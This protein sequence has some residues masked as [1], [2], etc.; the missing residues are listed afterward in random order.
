MASKQPLTRRTFLKAA[1]AL[2]GWAALESSGLNRIACAAAGSGPVDVFY[3]G[4]R[5]LPY[6][7]LTF[8]DCYNLDLLQELEQMLSAHRHVQVTFFPTGTALENTSRDD[9]DLWGRLAAQGHEIGSHSYQHQFA[10]TLSA[11]EMQD[12]FDR[13]LE[14]AHQA[15]GYVPAVRFARPAYGELAFAFMKLCEDRGLVPTMWST[16]WGTA[17]E[18]AE[19]E[20][21]RMR[22][23]EIALLHIR[24]WDLENTR[25]AI[26]LMAE[27]G[28]KGV[29]LSTLYNAS[30]D[31]HLECRP[32]DPCAR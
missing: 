11:Q 28:F 1:L 3:Q 14:A 20:I 5:R 18:R 27:R 13:W 24:A 6:V 23:G 26:R 17:P 7:A 25:L 16:N 2:G 10:S 22:G 21:P 30:H 29:T 32:G 19:Q 15:L 31:V 12:D 9:P 8:D 4:K